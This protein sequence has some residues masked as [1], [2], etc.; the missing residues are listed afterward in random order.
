MMENKTVQN[1]LVIVVGAVI[2]LALLGVISTLL[3]SILPL[4][5]VGIV[6]FI[7]GRVSTRVDLLA[8]TRAFVVDQIIPRLRGSGE[9]KAAEATPAQEQAAKP[10][11]VPAREETRDEPQ[12]NE[13]EE[14]A[15]DFVIKD[16][17]DLAEQARRLEEDVAKRTADYD[18][19]AAIEERKRRLLGDDE[20]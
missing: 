13:T 1:I 9:P 14:E 15:T 12:G 4:A 7:L 19:Q 8:A 18:A 20:G 11:E 17:K 3:T 10:V 16:E 2:V 5:L 6:A